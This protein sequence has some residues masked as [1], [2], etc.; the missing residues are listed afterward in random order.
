VRAPPDEAA[1]L[2]A[3]GALERRLPALAEA[4]LRDVVLAAGAAKHE[5]V[6]KMREFGGLFALVA[7]KRL[8]RHG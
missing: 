4:E 8:V 1:G 2:A 7:E 5:L 6:A 3:D